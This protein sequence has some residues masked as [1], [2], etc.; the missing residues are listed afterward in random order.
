MIKEYL[1]ENCPCDTCPQAYKCELDELAC[2]AFSTFVLYGRFDNEMAR[3]PT[4]HVFNKVFKEDDR[5]LSIYMK[6][7][8]AKEAYW[9]KR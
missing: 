6:S 7:V 8:K 5:A 3:I 2:G 4:H 9:G 1:K